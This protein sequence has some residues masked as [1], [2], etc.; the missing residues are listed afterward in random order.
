MNKHPYLRAYLAGIAVPTVFL[1]IAM[2]LYTVFR[3]RYNCS[4]PIERLIVFPMA[5]VPNAWGLWNVLYVALLARRHFSLGLFGSAL[6]LLLGPCGYFVARM[7]EFPVPHRV[8]VVVPFAFP[9]ALI[10]Y[11]LAWKYFVGFLNAELGIA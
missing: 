7:L 1:L 4:I 9:I 6:P 2:T 8:F 11:Y 5:A 3:Y 10:I